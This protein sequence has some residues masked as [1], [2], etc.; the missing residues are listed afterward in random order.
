MNK[1]SKLPAFDRS[2]FTIDKSLNNK[3]KSLES[4]PEHLEMHTKLRALLKKTNL[5]TE[6]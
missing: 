3:A 1:K 4:N 6:V 5:S 2:L